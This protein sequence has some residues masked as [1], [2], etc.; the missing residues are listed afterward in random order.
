MGFQLIYTTYPIRLQAV[1]GESSCFDGAASFQ[2]LLFR[3][4]G[5]KPFSFCC[6]GTL[7]LVAYYSCK[8]ISSS[9]REAASVL[10]G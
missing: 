1:E 9:L 6:F 2:S 8:N 4:Q 3:P 10:T 7:V 5:L